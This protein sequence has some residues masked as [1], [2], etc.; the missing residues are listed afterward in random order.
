MKKIVNPKSKGYLIEILNGLSVTL[1]HLLRRDIA[2]IQYPE[3]RREYSDR[4]RGIHILT[5][6]ENGD[7]KCVACYMCQTVCPADCI[8]IVAEEHED[9]MI[10]KRPKSFEID[11]MRCIMCGFCV[12]ACPKEALIMSNDFEMATWTRDEAVYNLNKLMGRSK[13]AVSGLG[14]RP[15]YD[16]DQSSG[17]PTMVGPGPKD[18]FRPVYRDMLGRVDAGKLEAG[19]E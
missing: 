19:T 4:F 1:K 7:P 12:E 15:Y 16:E 14:F 17:K 18:S 5:R 9:P 10:E 2:T 11:L 8:T 13:L 6:R 3:Q